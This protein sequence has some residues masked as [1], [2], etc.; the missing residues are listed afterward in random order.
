M[1]KVKVP[2]K[3]HFFELYKKNIYSQN[4][5]DGVLEEIINRL[6]DKDGYVCEFGAW[7]GKHLSNTFNLVIKGMKAIYIEG[8]E[9]RY[10][11]LQ[12]TSVKY[13]NILAIQAYVDHNTSSVSSLDNI[14][15]KIQIPNDFLML[16]IDIDSYDY[17]VWAAFIKYKP[18]IVVI[19]INS[20]INPYIEDHI[21]APGKYLGTSFKPM[22]D[23]GMKKGYKFVLHTGNMIFIRED[24]YDKLGITYDDPIENFRRNWLL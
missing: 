15:S 11:K 20:H 14:L 5:E 8:D 21:H 19:E 6:G 23:L 18:K 9:E 10:K 16:S 7:D 13:P 22:Y 3:N 4:G 24:L 12:E 2:Y 17:Q 1:D